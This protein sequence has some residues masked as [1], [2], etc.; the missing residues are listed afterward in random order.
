MEKLH[1]IYRVVVAAPIG[2]YARLQN[3]SREVPNG[4]SD[5]KGRF[6]E[7]FHMTGNVQIQC[8]IKQSNYTSVT[9]LISC[10]KADPIEN[11]VRE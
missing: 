6:F 9:R 1:C 11:G 7:T 3:H 8:V 4:P 10:I 5:L 2:Q